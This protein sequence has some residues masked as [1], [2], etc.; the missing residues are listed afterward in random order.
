MN[1]RINFTAEQLPPPHAAL[2]LIVTIPAKNESEFI[3]PTLQVLTRQELGD[4]TKAC[5]EVIVL[6]NH[7]SDA[8][9]K[10]CIDFKQNNPD[11]NLH[12]LVTY[13]P[14]INNVGAARKLMMDLAASRLA[15][16]N[17]LIAM[18]DADTLV[19][20]KLGGAA[21]AVYPGSH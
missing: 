8:T 5:Y 15:Q 19:G 21:T 20:K 7:S 18:T 9:L 6:I 14:E 4:R 1:S 3:I 11:F 13:A 17:Y 12:I 10:K 2:Q 16:D